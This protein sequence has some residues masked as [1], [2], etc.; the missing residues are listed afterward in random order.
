MVAG[1]RR[2]R[3]GGGPQHPGEHE[4]CGGTMAGNIMMLFGADNRAT[5][6]GVTTREARTPSGSCAGDVV[7]STML[8]TRKPE[9]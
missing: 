4:V 8:P 6:W 2:R 1:Y 9:I 7:L 5:Q 3:G